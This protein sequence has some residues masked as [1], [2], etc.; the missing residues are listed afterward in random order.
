MLKLILTGAWVAVV[1]L[2]AVYFSIQ[3]SKA[4]DPDEEAAKQKAIQELVR[5]EVTTFPVIG[6]GHVEGYFLTRTSYI[7]DK[8][9]MTTIGMPIS[10][11]L[12]D[13]LYTALVGDKLIRV[14]ENKNFDLQAFRERVKTA[15]N[16]RLGAD[17][18]MDIVVEQVDYLSKEDIRTSMAQKQ[19]T[20][21]GGKKIIAE[22]IPT[23][24]HEES[25][26][27]AN[28]GH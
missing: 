24:I 23:D 22:K 20:L 4:P 2:G 9:K 12:T 6:D 21:S 10:V 13:E 19:T 27:E 7:V 18:V 8:T 15:L 5:G 3:M 16:K 28:A 26:A 14:G 25:A 11:L 1:T 17:V